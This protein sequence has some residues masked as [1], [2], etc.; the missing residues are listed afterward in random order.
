MNRLMSKQAV[1][2]IV[3]EMNDEVFGIEFIVS[4]ILHV[5]FSYLPRFYGMKSK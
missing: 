3:E 1:E 5:L 2:T 4:S